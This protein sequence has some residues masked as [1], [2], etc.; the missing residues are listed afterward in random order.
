MFL[1]VVSGEVT[2][3][4]QFKLKF[5]NHTV[6]YFNLVVLAILL[7]NLIFSELI[8]VLSNLKKSLL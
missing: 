6:N 2:K 3:P 4:H 1:P 8:L 7:G 5:W